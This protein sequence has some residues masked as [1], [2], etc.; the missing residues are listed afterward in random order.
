MNDNEGERETPDIHRLYFF[1]SYA[2]SAPLTE[3][4]ESD[5]DHLVRKFFNDLTAAVQR[6]ASRRS[7]FVAGFFDQEIPVN[8]DW[9]KSIAKALGSAEVFVPLY[10]ARYVAR[11]WPGREWASFH[12]R[13]ELA[14]LP[15][16][17]LRFAPVLWTPLAGTQHL[18]GFREA[19][20][21][22][23]GEP[24]YAENGL[25]A[26]L[27]IRS[28]HDSY[29]AVVNVLAQRIVVLA[30]KSPIGPSAV[31]HV[32]KMK[33]AF[34]PESR[35][36]VFAIETAAPTARTI[37]AGHEPRGYGQNSAEW[38]PFPRQE[39]PLA[40]Y[41]RQVAERFDFQAEV[42]EIRTI[43]E[44]RTRKPGIILIDPWFIADKNGQAVLESA[45]DQLPR[46][47][48]PL[49]ILGQPSDA[50]TKELGDQ[51]RLMLSA[52][53]ALP[54]DSSRRG[55]RGVSSLDEFVTIMPVL[56]AEAERQYLRY[57][58]GR[59]PSSPS[60]KRPSLR[61]PM[62]PDIPASAPDAAGEAPDA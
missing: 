23:A 21:L 25:L 56:V 49:L 30:E 47:V 55:A 19:L 16:P 46:W 37:T 48:L 34:Q 50:R 24:G 41:A 32:E 18:P 42:S 2:H 20:E 36:A 7:E 39:L 12:R 44:P 29:R 13:M 1:L 62:R 40:Q 14:G 60:A 59:V 6:H 51:I 11:A 58:S 28:Y 15:D 9:K 26:M 3:Y 35:L 8:S 53:G 5:P 52:A 54:T 4:P 43:R 38:R 27:K 45:V 57:R 33:S 22:G 61:R 10:S 17:M 31:P